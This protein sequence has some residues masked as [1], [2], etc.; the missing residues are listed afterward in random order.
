MECASD[1][2]AQAII[3]P[4]PTGSAGAPAKWMQRITSSHIE[5]SVCFL[6]TGDVYQ[7]CI[8]FM[9]SLRSDDPLVDMARFVKGETTDEMVTDDNSLPP[10][11]RTK[12][13]RLYSNYC[14]AAVIVQIIETLMRGGMD[15]SSIGVIA[16]YAL[17]VELLKQIINKTKNL[18]VE[19]NTVDQYQGRDKEVGNGVLLITVDLDL[20]ELVYIV[21]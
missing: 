20:P 7:R 16:P 15:G 14:E 9:A 19:V 1:K 12:A 2:V 13:A 6:N 8:E 21:V 3:K 11:L 10:G 4:M 5:Q 18:N 17:Q